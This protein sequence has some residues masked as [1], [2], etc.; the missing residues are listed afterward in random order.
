MTEDWNK[1]EANIDRVW[2]NYIDDF[3]QGHALGLLQETCQ[4]SFDAYPADTDPRDMKVLLR[5]DADGRAFSVRDFDTTGMSHCSD[6]DW[7]KTD[8]GPCLNERE[9]PWGAFHNMGYTTKLSTDSLG[10]RGMGKSLQILAGERTVIRTTLPDGVCG[11]SEWVKKDDWYWRNA[12]E[13][14]EELSA[15]GTE[16]VTTGVVDDVHDIL[17]DRDA[18]IE[19]LQHRWFRPL[20]EGA[21]LTYLL[22]ENGKKKRRQIGAPR[23][24]A[25]AKADDG[26][27]AHLEKKKIVISLKGKRLGEIRNLH[28]FMAKKPLRRDDWRQG[29]ALVKNGKQT[30]AHYRDFSRGIPE[31]TR[32]RIY[33]WCN[34]VCTQED[35]FLEEAETSTHTGYKRYHPTYKAVK[36]QL[37]KIVRRFAE[38][39]IG[40]GGERVTDRDV[41]EADEILDVINAALGSVEGFNLFELGDEGDV[42][43]TEPKEPPQYV[44]LSRLE[45]ERKRFNRGE[46]V[47]VKAVV[48]NPTDQELLV[49]VQFE[50]FDPTPVVVNEEEEGLIMPPGSPEE[51]STLEAEW[52]V[53]LDDS[54]APG[55]HWIQVALRDTHWE[56]F[57]DDEGNS[58]KARRSLF[59]EEDPPDIKRDRGKRRKEGPGSGGGFNKLRPMNRPELADTY[60]A[61]IDPSQAEAYF[62]LAGKRLAHQRENAQNRKGYW[63]TIGEVLGEEIVRHLVDRHLE[64]KDTWSQDEVHELVDD[65]VTKK[66]KFEQTI[67]DIL[68]KD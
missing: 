59:C 35:P 39:F 27:D 7:G 48:K 21:D 11:A 58:I 5:Y 53:P 50:H 38:P 26:S 17:I 68:A 4:N 62:N 34:V 56:P 36:R 63:P 12:P 37:N 47:P 9:C 30:I 33:G 29:I 57:T 13:E 10:S 8:E 1:P 18:I 66:A 25:V 19:E 31:E 61:A 51:P 45:V 44:Y 43:D 40:K 22:V 55:R 46:E 64:K 16:M 14:E 2:R 15:P 67:V 32:R 41:K 23:W 20:E 49:R 3:P 54:L 52:D 28:L 60:E 24:P 65:L 42:Q 6:C